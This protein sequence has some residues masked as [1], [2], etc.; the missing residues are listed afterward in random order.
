MNKIVNKI[1]L[2]TGYY[3]KLL[4]PERMTLLRTINNKIPKNESVCIVPHLEIAEV[5]SV[6]FNVVNND[7]QHDSRFLYTFFLNKLF[8]QLLNIS[9]KRFIF[10]KAFNS[11][12]SYLEVWFTNQSSKPQLMENEIFI[13]LFIYIFIYLFDLFIYL[14]I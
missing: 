11:E 12:F 5:V 9:P 10:L 14:F 2:K 13:F 4:T 3:L 1:K 7:Y 8:R 6:H